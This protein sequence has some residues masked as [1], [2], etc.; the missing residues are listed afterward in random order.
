MKNPPRKTINWELFNALRAQGIPVKEAIK[1]LGVSY[2]TIKRALIREKPGFVAKIGRPSSLDKNWKNIIALLDAGNSINETAEILGI[3]RSTLLYNIR[4]KGLLNKYRKQQEIPIAVYDRAVI[5]LRSD[6]TLSIRHTARRLGISPRA[7]DLFLESVNLKKEFSDRFKTTGKPKKPLKKPKVIF[8][9]I[10]RDIR[11]DHLFIA[12]TTRRLLTIKN[13][14]V[15]IQK[16]FS[17]Q[18]RSPETS[19]GD[20]LRAWNVS[21]K[22]LEDILEPYGL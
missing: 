17:K 2:N 10:Y 20:L 16:A 8:G 9:E 18:V 3:S 12:V 4:K 19:F 5:M 14:Q 15:K 22:E 1:H 21:P 11:N 13:K 7:L 6:R